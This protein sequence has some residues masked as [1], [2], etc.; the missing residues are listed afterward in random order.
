VK[1]F[2]LLKMGILIVVG[3]LTS[4][5]GGGGAETPIAPVIQAPPPVVL[6][7]LSLKISLKF[8]GGVGTKPEQYTYDVLVEKTSNTNIKDF[9]LFLREIPE[10]MQFTSSDITFSNLP[11]NVVKT[12][13]GAIILNSIVDGLIESS[14]TMPLKWEMTYRDIESSSDKESYLTV[15]TDVQF[16]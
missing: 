12:A 16:E 6:Q 11:E 5:C 9:K 8:I 10:F 14:E 4:A 15:S 7:P 2:D 3:G 1:N 13:P